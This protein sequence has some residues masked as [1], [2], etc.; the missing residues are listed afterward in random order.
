MSLT[1]GRRSFAPRPWAVVGAAALLAGCVALGL[2]QVGRAREKRTLLESFERGDTTTVVMSAADVDQLPRYQR[3]SAVGRYDAAHQVLLD[4]MPSSTGLPGYRVL[5]PLRRTNGGR[6]LLV[7]RGWVPLGDSRAQL[8][9]VAVRDGERQV[10][11]RLDRPPVPGIRVGP[12]QAPGAAGW[13]RVLNFPTADD[14]AA[15]LGEPVESR[16]L[17][18]DATEPE[19]YERVWRP[20]FGFPAERHLGY[21]VQWFALALAVLVG[22]VALSVKPATP[23]EDGRQ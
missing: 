18:L 14:L 13:P 23:A 21:A 12:A 2:W 3:V 22:F 16:I 7:D 15:A 6:L 20:S 1:I 17:L 4:N 5:T 8:P 19:G 9:D 11:G 10:Q